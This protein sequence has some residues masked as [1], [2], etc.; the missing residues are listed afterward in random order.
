MPWTHGVGQDVQRHFGKDVLERFHLEV[1]I[2]SKTLSC[3]R[4]APLSGGAR[5]SLRRSYLIPLRTHPDVAFFIGR[6]DPRRAAGR[7]TGVI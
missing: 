6:Q 2:P 4:D 1:P 7:R 3:R 5:A